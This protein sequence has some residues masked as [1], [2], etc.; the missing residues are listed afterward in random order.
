MSR[1]VFVFV[2]ETWPKNSAFASGPPFWTAVIT[3]F[4][5]AMR[6]SLEKPIP[7]FAHNGYR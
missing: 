7:E 2:F 3:D 1:V 4:D 5:D 6:A